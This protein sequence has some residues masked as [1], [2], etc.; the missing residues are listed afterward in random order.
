MKKALA[1]FLFIS[2]FQMQAQQ[3]NKDL[4]AMYHQ[5][6]FWIG[7]WEVYKFGTE[8][9]AGKSHIESIIDS[10]GILENYS[11]VKGSYVGKS[12]NKYNPDKKR[13]EQFWIDNSG[14]TLFLTGGLQDGKMIMDDTAYGDA[15][16]GLNK[17]VWEKM[18]NGSVRQTWSTSKDRGKTWVVL[19]DGEYKRAK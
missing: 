10:V 19:F 7:T 8:T 2:T 14:L 18:K 12:L 5:F 6:D 11:V 4:K 3:P 1:F 9:L 13:W 17:I 15:E 16:K